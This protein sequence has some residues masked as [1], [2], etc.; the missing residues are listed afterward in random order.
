MCKHLHLHCHISSAQ[1]PCVTTGSYPGRNAHLESK[2][3]RGSRRDG[4]LGES[5]SCI[6]MRTRDGI[7]APMQTSSAWLYVLSTPALELWVQAETGE[8]LGISGCQPSSRVRERP[9]L[10]GIKSLTIEKR[11]GHFLLLHTQCEYT[12]HT[13]LTQ[14]YKHAKSLLPP[15]PTKVVRIKNYKDNLIV[16]GQEIASHEPCLINPEM[17]REIKEKSVKGVPKLLFLCPHVSCNR[18]HEIKAVLN[19]GPTMKQCPRLLPLETM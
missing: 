10:E 7:P 17:Q 14:T 16:K 13:P 15:P 12:T 18:Q 6:S 8:S 11:T 2:R 19:T 3:H 9:C 5:T 4:S 1:Q